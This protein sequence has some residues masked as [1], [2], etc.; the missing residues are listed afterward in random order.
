[1]SEKDGFMAWAQ[2]VAILKS[3]KHPESAKLYLNWLIENQ[4]SPWGVRTDKTPPKG[5]KQIWEYKNSNMK[6]F[7]NF[8]MDRAGVESFKAQIRLFVGDVK[9]EPTP[10][11]LG[12]Y[13]DKPLSK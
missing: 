4:G 10:G 5:Y 8:M 2:R 13:P 7:E 11:E 3:T 9:G 12:L 1:M 6:E